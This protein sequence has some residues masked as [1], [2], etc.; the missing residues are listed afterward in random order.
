MQLYISHPGHNCH[1]VCYCFTFNL[2]C[3]R[4]Q[5]EKSVK[6]VWAWHAKLQK[7]AFQWPLELILSNFN[8]ETI[9]VDRY[10]TCWEWKVFL[11]LVDILLCW[12][13]FFAPAL[14]ISEFKRFSLPYALVT[15]PR[16]W[17]TVRS[18]GCWHCTAFCLVIMSL[19]FIVVCPLHDCS[20]RW[21]ELKTKDEEENCSSS[22][23]VL[24]FSKD[25]SIT[26]TESLCVYICFNSVCSIVPALYR[27]R[28]DKT[29]FR[30]LRVVCALA[31]CNS[32][33]GDSSRYLACSIPSRHHQHVCKLSAGSGVFEQFTADSHHSGE[34]ALICLWFGFLWHTGKSGLK[35]SSHLNKGEGC[36]S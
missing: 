10:Q 3:T 34:Q 6:P 7:T 12:W 24:W 16:L 23:L 5:T 1:T 19:A 26:N 2:L 30:E 22:L 15:L 32:F 21:R 8:R 14:F 27:S 11:T 17:N 18:S 13:H 31:G 35:S 28:H 29:G 36:E 25:N 4:G 9:C 33:A 20:N